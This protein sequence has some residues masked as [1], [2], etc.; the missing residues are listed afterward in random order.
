[1]GT[2]FVLCAVMAALIYAPS[3]VVKATNIAKA[4]LAKLF[5]TWKP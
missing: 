4:I 2:I 5:T 1:M 3:L